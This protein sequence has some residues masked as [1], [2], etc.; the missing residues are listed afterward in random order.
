M[1]IYK[2]EDLLKLGFRSVGE[3]VAISDKASFYSPELISIGNHVRVDDFCILSGN[4]VIGGYVHVAAYSA[5]F[6]GKKGI[7][8]SDFANIS[9][10]VNIYAL[11][12]DYSGESMTNPMIPDHYKRVTH[13]KVWIGRHVIIGAGSI[14]LPGAILNDGAAFGALS[15]V[16]GNIP[17][18]TMNVGIPCRTI[19][20]RKKDLLR[21]EREF[22]EEISNEQEI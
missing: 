13:E 17:G 6:G 21:Q 22:M 11:S 1:G 3:N 8:V 4:I 19:R 14:I 5:L 20:E 18:W 16:K 9:S 15:L 2:R 12:D 10:R 7:I